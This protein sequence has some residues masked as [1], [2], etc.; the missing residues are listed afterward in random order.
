MISILFC[1]Q[2]S[3]YSLLLFISTLKS[4]TLNCDFK[5]LALWAKW[6][7][8]KVYFLT[9]LFYIR[10]WKSVCLLRFHES[11]SCSAATTTSVLSQSTL[12]FQKA[13]VILMEMSWFP[14][15]SYIKN[16]ISWDSSVQKSS[17]PHPPSYAHFVGR[18][19]ELWE[20]KVKPPMKRIQMAK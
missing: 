4:F 14:L 10:C 1:V 20:W 12:N 8:T 17:Q 15:A 19:S 11:L 13:R 18:W 6:N 5:T 2:I 9:H 16:A 3:L 7:Q